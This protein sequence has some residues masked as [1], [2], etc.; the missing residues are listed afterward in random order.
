MRTVDPVVVATFGLC[1]SLWLLAMVWWALRRARKADEVHAR[2]RRL[3]AAD[4]TATSPLWALPSPAGDASAPRSFNQRLEAM[5]RAAGWEITAAPV[6]GALF[7][8]VLFSA[9]FSY[10]LLKNPLLS[11]GVG[12]LVLAT[13]Y[14]YLKTKIRSY[15][16]RFE[17]QFADALQLAVRS[18][19]AGL[20]MVG[21]L[22]L[23]ADEMG[24]PVGRLFA[25]VCQQHNLGISLEEALH[26][27]GARVHQPRPAAVRHLGVHP[28]QHRRQSRRHD[29][30][31][32]PRDPRAHEAGA[33][34]AG[35][36]L[37]DAAQQAH[38]ARPAVR[39]VPGAA[40][41]QP[42]VRRAVLRHRRRPA[43]D[44]H[45]R[46]A[47]RARRDRHE[48]HRDAGSLRR[49]AM[50][51]VMA[52]AAL[53]FMA[54]IGVGGAALVAMGA[55]RR[56]LRSR[57]QLAPTDA[58]AADQ[59]LLLGAMNRIGA[60]VLTGGGSKGLKECMSRA[61]FFQ[62]SAARTYLGIKVLLFGV[63]LLAAIALVLPLQVNLPMK[64]FLGCAIPA[65][66]FFAPNALVRLRHQRRCDEVRRHLP[67]V[68]DLLEVCVSAG[69]GLSKAWKTVSEEI[70]RVSSTLADEMAV[71]NLEIQLGGSRIAAMR[72]MAE[73]NNSDETASLAAFVVQSERFGTSLADTL[74]SFAATMREVR[75]Q[76]AEEAA[77]KMAVKLLFPLV[78]FIFPVMIIVMVGPAGI[79]LAEMMG[80]R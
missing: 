30:A 56:E 15:E 28:H 74:R 57:L 40:P 68:I 26:Q 42:E 77:E 32:C 18:L 43:D 20:P 36:E 66:L 48:S 80:S 53:T 62:D 46:R 41:A 72:R 16:A 11:L 60:S 73:R 67:D 33:A 17:S 61:G 2:L 6:L 12:T 5:F 24:P 19:R 44:R 78:L 4:A 25:E 8:L 49:M 29:G 38:P 63:G 7:T 10:V 71:A 37:A 14:L 22:R 21:T 64:T 76:K 27:D 50:V 58:A 65:A 52:I 1:L 9:A 23:V 35:V 13:F 34:R 3:D 51:L 69:M 79:K 59:G 45:Q 75:T 70:R 31:P 47:A 55:R 54:V 39:A